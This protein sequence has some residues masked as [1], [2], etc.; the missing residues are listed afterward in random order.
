[1]ASVMATPDLPPWRDVPRVEALSPDDYTAEYLSAGRPVVVVGGARSWPAYGRWDPE[2]LKAAVGD[3]RVRLAVCDEEFFGYTDSSATYPVEEMPFTE[4]C[5]LV[6]RRTPSARHFYVM[7][8]SLAREFPALMADVPRPDYVGGA[9][10]EPYL[11]FGTEGNVTPMHYDVSNN[12]FGQLRGRKRFLLFDPWQ[13]EWLYPRPPGSKHHNLTRVN[14][15]RPDLEQFPDFRRAQG[16]QCD[17]DPGDL[18]LLPAFWWHQVRSLEKG[19]S[20][21]IWW[22]PWPRDFLTPMARVLLPVLYQRSRL[23]GFKSL[24]GPGEFQ[25]FLLRVARFMAGQGEHGPAVILT[26]AA[27]DEALRLACLKAVK[28]IDLRPLRDLAQL[29]GAL[30]GAGALD[31]GEAQAVATVSALVTQ[32]L[33]PDGAAPIADPTEL[34]SAAERI[35]AR[36][37]AVATR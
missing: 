30:R 34:V 20:V 8:Q 3:K 33:S 22:T 31:E 9:P 35:T 12:V 11:W 19:L 32:A 6:T 37:G 14:P 13:S 7:Q 10:V 15:E 25:P 5:D 23:I 24:V 18:L 28:G 21:S 16:F 4:A 29:A 26:S 2:Y 17:L 1:M 27:L 36:L